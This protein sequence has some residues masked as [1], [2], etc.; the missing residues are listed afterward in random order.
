MRLRREL[1]R[2]NAMET[3]DC[4]ALLGLPRRFAL[5]GAQLDGAYRER[6]RHS[7]PDRHRLAD[8]AA[9][10]AAL[11]AATALNDAYHTLK[12][13]GRRAAHLLRLRGID[14]ERAR[15]APTLLM[16]QMQWHEA[17]QAARADGDAAA[18]RAL[19]AELR[20][21]LYACTDRLATALD[22]ATDPAVD[23]TVDMAGTDAGACLLEFGALRRLLEL[24]AA[25]DEEVDA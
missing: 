9:Q 13:P 3:A 16:Q 22:T 10:A 12:D 4:F 25:A 8:A 6:A 18:L 20:A 15:P 5:D 21:R 23:P 14:S 17:L 19:G 1:Q 2:L 11:G 7:H 24:L